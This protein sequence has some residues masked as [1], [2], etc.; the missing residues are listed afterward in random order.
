MHCVWVIFVVNLYEMQ[1]FSAV[2]AFFIMLKCF[3]PYITN[4][5]NAVKSVYNGKYTTE[6][7]SK[8]PD[9]LHAVR[10]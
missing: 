6:E 10:S 5:T 7:V 9:T 4:L 3:R 2:N 1:S 8:I